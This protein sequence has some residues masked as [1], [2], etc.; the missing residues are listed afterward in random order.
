MI[1]VGHNIGTYV[2]HMCTIVD[3]KCKMKMKTGPVTSHLH[4]TEFWKTAPIF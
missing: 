3:L 1:V 2:V 4:I